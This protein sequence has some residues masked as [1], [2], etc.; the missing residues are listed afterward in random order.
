MRKQITTFVCASAFVVAAFV[1][2]A[3]GAG[4]QG[5]PSPKVIG[6]GMSCGVCM[7]YPA[8]FPKWQTEIIFADSTMVPFDGC[9]DMFKYLLDMG[10]YTSDHTSADV[11]AVWVKDFAGGEWIMAKNAVFVVGSDMMGPMGKELI[12]FADKAAAEKFQR[13]NGGAIMAYDDITMETI[14]PLG[15][16]GMKMKGMMKGM[17]AKEHEMKMDGGGGMRM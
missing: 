13:Q 11:R 10:S 12:P 9:K 6:P 7:M 16:G 1:P 8:K 3:I 15:M 14:K 2:S 5:V 17:K 4:V